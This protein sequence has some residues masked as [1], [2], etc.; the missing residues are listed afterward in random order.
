MVAL[1][2]SSSR[3]AR[4]QY[5]S[6]Q[7]FII[8]GG[9]PDFP[10]HEVPCIANFICHHC[11]TTRPK[12]I[13][14]LYRNFCATGTWSWQYQIPPQALCHCK[15]TAS[16][17]LLPANPTPPKVK[18][19]KKNTVQA[20]GLVVTSTLQI[21]LG[22]VRI[23]NPRGLTRRSRDVLLLW[24]RQIPDKKLEL[25]FLLPP[26]ISHLINSCGL[27][28]GLTSNPRGRT[29]WCNDLSAA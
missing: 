19:S 17:M 24:C 27:R 28:T 4:I 11:N 22:T 6:G 29:R 16:R 1:L 15:P 13:R 10:P 18:K 26:R 23:S 14:G 3:F 9:R 12:V 25:R 20:N 2:H 21:E 5:S 8:L 7:A